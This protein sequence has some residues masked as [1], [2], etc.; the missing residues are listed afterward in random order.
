MADKHDFSEPPVED[1]E[2]GEG[3]Q[4]AAPAP[5]AANAAVQVPVM[6]KHPDDAPA[7]LGDGRAA[8][9]KGHPVLVALLALVLV[10]LVA[11]GGVGAWAYTQVQEQARYVPANTMLDGATSI[12]GLSSAEVAAVVRKQVISGQTPGLTLKVGDASYTIKYAKVGSVDAEA[13]ARAALALDTRD[14]L[15]RCVD[16][17][18]GEVGLG[19]QPERRSVATVYTVDEA[20]LKARLKEIARTVDADAVDAAYSYDEKSNALKTT[21]AVEGRQFKVKKTLDAILAVAQAGETDATVE[22]VIETITPEKAELGQ[23]IFV[24][25]TACH[26]YFYVDGEVV[27]D[28]PCTPGMSGYS[29]PTGDW[30]LS[31]KDPSPTWYNPHSDWSKNMAE[32]IPPGETNPLGLRALAV[33]CGGGIYIHGTT[34]LSQLGTAASHGCV[35]LAN[36]SVVELYDLVEVNIPII[37]R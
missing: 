16:F 14:T 29:T 9:K 34:A 4:P 30:Y 21:E 10:V 11:T 24:D 15:T 13:T 5:S 32:T 7:S 3:P 22:A 35:R 18:L 12:G 8:G 1:A 33:S 23:A 25:T 6:E 19:A 17:L 31:A 26:L 2:H 36:A 27:K 28:Y 20:K 37:I